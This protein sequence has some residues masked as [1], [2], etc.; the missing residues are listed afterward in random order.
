M[1]A[2]SRCDTISLPSLQWKCKFNEPTLS[3][4]DDDDVAFLIDN[5]KFYSSCPLTSMC[6]KKKLSIFDF[7]KSGENSRN[8]SKML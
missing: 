6:D 2:L 4:D 8:E 7:S 3:D 1:E 5:N